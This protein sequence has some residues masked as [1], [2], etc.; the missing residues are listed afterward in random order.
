MFFRLTAMPLFIVTELRGRPLL[1]YLPQS[2]AAGTLPP[3]RV[4][5]TI[6]RG[7]LFS[8]NPFNGPY[9]PASAYLSPAAHIFPATRHM[10]IR[11]FRLAVNVGLKHLLV[12]TGNKWQQ[13]KAGSFNHPGRPFRDRP[14]DD[15][16]D[17]Q[18]REEL[19]QLLY[20]VWGKLIR[21][22][23]HDTGAVNASD[24]KGLRRIKNRR[25]PALPD[26]DCDGETCIYPFHALQKA[27]HV[28]S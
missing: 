12:L 19:H 18:I 11:P 8:R 4:S 13:L 10:Q 21:L 7:N 25:D 27:S 24:Q 22:L 17:S 9:L 23:L 20:P 28:P 26:C 5:R 16:R 15:N 1:V 14:A 3:G 6:S 2:L